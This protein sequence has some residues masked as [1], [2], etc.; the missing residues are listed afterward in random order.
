MHI[1][2]YIYIYIYRLRECLK[3]NLVDSQ[4]VSRIYRYMNTYMSI[5]YEEAT[6]TYK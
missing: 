5:V 1:Y 2:I 4:V 6:V 3:R